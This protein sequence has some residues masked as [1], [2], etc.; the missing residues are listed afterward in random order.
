MEYKDKFGKTVNIGDF[1]IV[2]DLSRLY[3]VRLAHPSTGYHLNII[4]YL[5]DYDENGNA[6]QKTSWKFIFSHLRVSR[7]IKIKPE[8]Y[9]IN[10]AI[11]Y[12]HQKQSKFY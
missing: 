3:I 6:Y 2:A 7:S 5:I 4:G 9:G 10:E 1:V 8:D 11:I 12:R